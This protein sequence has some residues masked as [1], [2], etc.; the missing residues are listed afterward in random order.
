MVKSGAVW[1]VLLAE[2]AFGQSMDS[3]IMFE[4]F[5]AEPASFAIGFSEPGIYWIALLLPVPL[6]YM[7]AFWL[8]PKLESQ[9]T[10]LC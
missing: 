4:A 1:R 9:Q 10:E 3:I 5:L 7:Y 6:C 8:F 2:D